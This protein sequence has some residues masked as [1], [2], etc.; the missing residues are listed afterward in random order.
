MN[1]R[2]RAEEHLKVI[3]TLMERATIYRAISAPTAL[4]AGLL[5][6]TLS[7]VS[8]IWQQ[9]AGVS[10]LPHFAAWWSLVLL[11]TVAANTLFLW[12][13]A[14]SRNEPML[15]SS[16]K[17]ALKALLP[18]C[19]AAGVITAATGLNGDDYFL[20]ILW[21]LFYG[22]A[23]LATAHFSPKSLVFLG[24]AFLVAGLGAFL[25][26]FAQT[27]GNSQLL[28]PEHIGASLLMGVTFGGFHLVYAACTWRRG[29]A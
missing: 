25:V 23:L 11:L 5:A 17:L 26:P 14:Q 16:M 3:R 9:R 12:R 19:L 8:L 18:P 27:W 10:E 22:L 6:A 1:E 28:W 2:E 24:W 4:V 13:A 15:S 29:A 20:S 7:S 21:T